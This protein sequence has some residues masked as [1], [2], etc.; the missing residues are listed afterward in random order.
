MIIIFV[1][2]G[3]LFTMLQE[4]DRIFTNLYGFLNKDINASIKRGDWSV[5][6]EAITKGREFIINEVKASGLRGR[7]G[8][9]CRA[10]RP[11][12]SGWS[13]TARAHC[14]LGSRRGRCR[15]RA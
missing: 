5:A 8:A 3:E 13:G 10:A 12:A 4:K 1:R 2:L 14:R 7:G 15:S 11:A 6:K 9:G